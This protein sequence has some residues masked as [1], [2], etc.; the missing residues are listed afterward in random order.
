M[1]YSRYNVLS[2]PFYVVNL[3]LSRTSTTTSI[4]PHLPPQKPRTNQGI[5][6]VR[7]S[8][9]RDTVVLGGED[10]NLYLYAAGE[11]YD[12]IATAAKHKHPVGR[13]PKRGSRVERRKR[14]KEGEG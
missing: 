8:P 1:L 2:N 10:S 3:S 11:N 9:D 6:E 7:W 14:T 12:L 13:N 4:L 5:I